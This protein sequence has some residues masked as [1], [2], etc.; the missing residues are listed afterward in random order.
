MNVK[1]WDIKPS[2]L[3]DDHCEGK[4]SIWMLPFPV[5]HF[6]LNFSRTVDKP[7]ERL[8]TCTRGFV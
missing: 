6:V 5:L 1:Q 8:D 3:R 7:L 4:I 2:H